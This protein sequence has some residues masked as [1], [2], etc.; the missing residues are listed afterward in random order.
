MKKYFSFLPLLLA[1]SVFLYAQDKSLPRSNPE[2]EGVTAKGIIDFLDAAAKSKNEMHSFMFLRHGKVIAEG[3][4]DP[5]KPGLK[6]TMY[7]LSKSFT[8][9]GVGLAVSEGKLKLTDKVISFFPEYVPAQQSEYLKNLTVKD[10]LTMSVGQ[11]PDPTPFIVQHDSNWI[12]L[13]L[14]LPIQHQPGTVFLYNTMA[15]FMLS[16]IVQKVAGQKLIDYLKPRLFDPLNIQGMDEEEDASGI[17]T[18]GWGLRIKTEDMAKFGQLYLQKGNWQGKQLLPSKWVQEATTVKIMQSPEITGSKRDSSDWL[19][20]YCYQFWRCRH[21]AY[22][23]DGAFGQYIIVLPDQDAVIAIT[24]ETADMQNELNLVWDY[25]LPSISSSTLLRNTAADDLLKQRLAALALPFKTSTVAPS[26]AMLADQQ[27]SF[28]SN[29]KH[30]RGIGL[31][32]ENDRCNLTLKTDAAT[33]TIGFS[34]AGQLTGE[35]EMPGPSLVSGSK[36]SIKRLAPYK[37]A[38]HYYWKDDHT[39]ELKLRYIESPHTL[40]ITC[41]LDGDKMTA[42]FNNS[43]EGNKTTVITGKRATW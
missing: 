34:S 6:H 30:I 32:F 5:Y 1:F 23:G 11:A 19:Q 18:G 4:W 10:L 38:G 43:F 2:A 29:A 12:K 28:D 27:F 31:H 24:S 26:G 33:Y 41:Q 20:G 35:T 36:S 17:N 42:S 14:A 25:L 40:S 3:W 37:I 9:T 39:L 13:F 16:A 22:R 7:S 15:T 21:N 8:S